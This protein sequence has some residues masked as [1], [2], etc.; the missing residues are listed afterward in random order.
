M[1]EPKQPLSRRSFLTVAACAGVAIALPGLQACA[2]GPSHRAEQF[3][4]AFEAGDENY[5]EFT[6][7]VGRTVVLPRQIKSVSPSGPLAQLLLVTI[8]PEL[9]VSLA[10]SFSKTQ[11]R[12]LGEELT[13]LPVLGRFY[14]VNADMNYEEIIRMSPDVII[15]IGTAKRNIDKDMDKLQEQTGLPTIF[16]EALITKMDVAYEMLG[17]ALGI[18]TRAQTLANYARETLAFA[19]KHHDEIAADGLKI[20]YASGENGLDV[21]KKGSV[22]SGVIDILGLDNVAVLSDTNST[23]VSIE[24][25]MLWQPEVLLLSSSEGYFQ[26]IF[27]D[28]IWKDVSA[29][30]NRR[31]YEVPGEPYEWLDRPPSV[32]MLLGLKWLG[33][34]LYPHLYNFDIVKKTQEFYK[35]FWHYDLSTAEAHGLLANSS[36]LSRDSGMG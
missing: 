6:D 28:P 35:L 17:D 14:G 22:H 27:D 9:L 33:N 29:V 26:D 32:Q 12:Y 23:L 8:C 7:S 36:F 3:R 19:Y 31:T 24:Q 34:L 30:K 2:R 21:K 13:G 10:T 20:M 15:D 4:A 16:I 18:T 11:A 25:V 5:R 1:S